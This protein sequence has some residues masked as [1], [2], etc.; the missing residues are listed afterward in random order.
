M[1]LCITAQK[2]R[3]AKENYIRK[4]TQHTSALTIALG[5]YIKY[6]HS[7]PLPL[8]GRHKYKVIK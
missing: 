6:V 8:N 7:L 1:H 4:P 5:T 2:L 3:S